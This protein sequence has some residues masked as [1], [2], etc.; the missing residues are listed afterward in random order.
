M[1]YSTVYKLIPSATMIK[2]TWLLV[3]G[4]KYCASN[5]VSWLSD[6]KYK[7]LQ[8]LDRS[9]RVTLECKIEIIHCLSFTIFIKTTKFRVETRNVDLL[10]HWCNTIPVKHLVLTVSHS[11]HS[12]FFRLLS[13]DHL[14]NHATVFS[15]Y[16]HHLGSLFGYSSL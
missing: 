3:F 8:I 16:Y 5:F 9:V 15:F 1:L 4:R 10:N 2:G 14:T 13:T 7:S 11:Y 6:T 12:N